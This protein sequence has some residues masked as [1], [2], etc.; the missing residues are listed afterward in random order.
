MEA[1]LELASP[2]GRRQV[3]INDFYLGYKKFDLR[4]DELLTRVMHPTTA[5]ERTVATVQN[6][7]AARSRHFYVH[8]RNSNAARR[9]NDCEALIAYGAVG[10]TVM[11]LRKTEAI[12]AR[13]AVH[14]RNHGRR[15]RRS[16]RRNHADQRRP[17]QRGLSLSTGPQC[18]FEV[19]S[20]TSNWRPRNAQRRQTNSARFGHWSCDRHGVVH[21]RPADAG[22]RTARR[23]CR[24]PG[25]RADG[26]SRSTFAAAKALPGSRRAFTRPTICPAKNTSA[27]CS[28][29]NRSWPT[30][31]CCTSA[32]RSW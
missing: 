3:K 18:A 10:P 24:Q 4:P 21:R 9:R 27:R 11:R 15:R 30:A 16:G 14:R 1:E 28:E 31:K 23:L 6:L 25:R 7:A 26:S 8:R 17:R 29:M 22:R 13:P 12:L 19:L 32:S 2:R 5:S 20:R